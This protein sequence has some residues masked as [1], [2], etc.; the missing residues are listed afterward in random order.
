MDW[1]AVGRAEDL[2]HVLKA[3]HRGVSGRARGRE[4]ALRRQ[5]PPSPSRTSMRDRWRTSRPGLAASRP[6]SPTEVLPRSAAEGRHRLR[7]RADIPVCRSAPGYSVARPPAGSPRR[8]EA[9]FLCGQGLRGGVPVPAEKQVH[10]RVLG[11]HG[12]GARPR[13]KLQLLAEV[14]R[15]DPFPDARGKHPPAAEHREHHRQSR[16][17]R[18]V[19]LHG[20]QG[21]H[22]P[23]LRG[24][25]PP[26]LHQP[27]LKPLGPRRGRIFCPRGGTGTCGSREPRTPSL[28]PARRQTGPWRP[29]Q[30]PRGRPSLPGHWPPG[31]F[32]RTAGRPRHDASPGVGRSVSAP[33][34]QPTTARRRRPAARPRP[35]RPTR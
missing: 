35:D 12:T 16:H 9:R 28:P 4:S 3:Y 1:R 18:H 6:G 34:I 19:P 15:R 26:E 25:G 24:V 11:P 27:D 29:G 20:N 33:G 31:P 22:E 5:S 21:L 30:S 2:A 14:L 17:L 23:L 8:P 7:R 10:A 13:Q 32:P